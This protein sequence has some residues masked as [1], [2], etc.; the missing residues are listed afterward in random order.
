M[1][2]QTQY[3][4][5][6]AGLCTKVL[7]IAAG[8]FVE[9]Q[10]LAVAG[11]DIC[12][13]L[14]AHLGDGRVK[15]SHGLGVVPEAGVEPARGCPQQIFQPR[16]VRLWRKV[17]CVCRFQPDGSSIVRIKSLPDPLFSQFSRCRATV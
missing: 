13:G 2:N 9:I 11:Q 8:S 3:Y 15:V 16:L 14:G 12:G 10:R 7:E 4:I 1:N 6:L 5:L 17:R